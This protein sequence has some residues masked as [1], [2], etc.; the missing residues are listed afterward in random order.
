MF[1]RN[2]VPSFATV[3]LGF[4]PISLLFLLGCGEEKPVSIVSGELREMSADQVIYGMEYYLSKEGGREAHIEAD[5]AY[6]Y[7]DS[8]VWHL[9]GVHL[10]VYDARTGQQRAAVS[11]L[12]GRLN[13]N[14]KE[15]TSHGRVV[16]LIPEGNR[17]IESSELFYHPIRNLLW[18][19]SYSIMREGGRTT[20]GD[21]FQSDLDFRKVEIKGA[22]TVGCPPG[23]WASSPWI[24]SNGVRPAIHPARTASLLG[25][26]AGAT[27][28]SERLAGRAAHGSRR[29]AGLHPR[30]AR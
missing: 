19:N 12:A 13:A 15:M 23:P 18:S 28:P 17:R 27:R 5:T 7:E 22:R 14:T 10:L 6:F 1:N 21:S 20:C 24:K 9:R 29:F 16:L 11:S 8:T 25:R 26:V 3:I 2:G 4:G 30:T